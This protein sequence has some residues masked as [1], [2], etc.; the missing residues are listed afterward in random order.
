ML[1]RI[2]QKFLLLLLRPADF[3]YQMEPRAAR[4]VSR[5]PGG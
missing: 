3:V 2:A 1:I 5:S 4:P